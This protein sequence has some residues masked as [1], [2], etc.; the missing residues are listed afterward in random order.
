MKVHLV[1]G[2][3]GCYSDWTTW[4]A[5]GY[6]KGDD[7]ESHIKRLQEI[8]EAWF[9]EENQNKQW[10]YEPGAWSE[11]EA[12]EDA[13]KQKIGLNTGDY[14]YGFDNTPKFKRKELDVT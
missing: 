2:E 6:F 9:S 12:A 1:I 4:V 10:S 7:A 13:Y 3:Q 8:T 5:A 14:L 11:W